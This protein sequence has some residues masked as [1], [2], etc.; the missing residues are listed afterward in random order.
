MARRTRQPDRDLADACVVEALAIVEEEGFEKLSLREVARRLGVSHQAPYKHFPSRDHIVAEMVARA[1]AGFAAHLDARGPAGSPRE[2]LGAMGRAYL[3][4]ALA[5]PLN[6]R[7]MFGTPLPEAGDHPEMMRLAR[8]A[9]SLLEQALARVHAA[10]GRT[11]PADLVEKDALFVWS[12]M[13]GLVGILRSS[14][15]PSLGIAPGAL[16]TVPEHVLS[17]I[18]SALGLPEEEAGP[19]CL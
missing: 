2:D 9:F 5:H 1:F 4:Y 10:E 3:G 13:H 17:R 19:R 18:G 11:V 7:L 16:A 15:A 12:V 6:Y 8:H 14:V